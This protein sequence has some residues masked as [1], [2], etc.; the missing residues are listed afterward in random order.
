MNTWKHSEAPAG[1]GFANMPSYSH[2][3]E[4]VCPICKG[5]LIRK[6]LTAVRCVKCGYEPTIKDGIKASQVR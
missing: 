3:R 5:M 4:P 2:A 1:T 6:T